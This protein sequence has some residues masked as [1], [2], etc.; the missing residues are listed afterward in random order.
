MKRFIESDSVPKQERLIV[1]IDELP[2]IEQ[3][4]PFNIKGLC[5]VENFISSEEERSLLSIISLNP[6]DRRLKRR[7]QHYGYEYDYATKSVSPKRTPP[8]PDWCEFVIERLLKLG[9]IKER[10]DQM[11]VNEYMPGQGIFPHVDDIHSF[12][13]GIVSLSLGSRIN[14]DLIHN[15][16][17]YNKKE[18]VLERKS[19][20]AFHGVARYEWRHGIAARLCDRGIPRGRRVS[21]TFR[22]MKPSIVVKTNT[23][24]EHHE[25]PPPPN[26]PELV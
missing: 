11:I 9:I 14:M 15:R 1:P 7:T 23:P 20:L 16:Q 25:T 10:P 24:L 17:S 22:K 12:D 18:L 6:W 26:P 8:M 21:L 3:S 19:V 5:L 13:D 2:V 4:N